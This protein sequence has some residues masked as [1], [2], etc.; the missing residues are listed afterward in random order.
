MLRRI[1]RFLRFDR[2]ATGRWLLIWDITDQQELCD[3]SRT[4]SRLRD[5]TYGAQPNNRL[6]P[7]LLGGLSHDWSGLQ[8]ADLFANMALHRQGMAL[9]LLGARAEK[10]TAFRRHLE[11]CLQR[12]ARGNGP[13]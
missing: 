12:D 6:V 10:A 8:A 2:K 7:A 1:S 5:T 13:S 4:I 3:F 11:P 9:G